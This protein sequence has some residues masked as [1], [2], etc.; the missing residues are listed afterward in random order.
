[1]FVWIIDVRSFHPNNSA[2]AWQLRHFYKI[3][4][5]GPQAGFLKYS[6][7]IIHWVTCTVDLE[8]SHSLVHTSGLYISIAEGPRRGI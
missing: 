2:E 3:F 8:S 7:T 5:A 6:A 1:M 4:V